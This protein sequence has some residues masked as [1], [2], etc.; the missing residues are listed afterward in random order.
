[1]G[2]SWVIFW[3]FF[4]QIYISFYQLS[5]GALIPSVSSNRYLNEKLNHKFYKQ[6]KRGVSKSKQILN[7]F[8][9][10]EAVGQRNQAEGSTR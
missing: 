7:N 10:P 4:T 5:V 9:H 8:R 3:Q 1:M 2:A 6:Q